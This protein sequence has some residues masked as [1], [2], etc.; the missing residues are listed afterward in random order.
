MTRR[1]R[2]HADRAS[3]ART[4][5]LGSTLAVGLALVST[6]AAAA[7]NDDVLVEFHF[8]PVPNTQIAI[9]LVDANGQFVQDVFVTQAT[10]TLGIGNR[11]GRWDFLSS[12]RF[13]YGPRPQVLPVWA[14]ARGKN[15]PSLKFHDDDPSD[16]DSLG[17]HENS[18]SPEP[19]FCRPLSEVENE[20]IS[21]DTMT[22]PSPA[23][24]QSD[25]GRF[26]G[27]QTPYPPRNDLVTFEDGGDHADVHMFGALNDLDA[28]TGATPVG[29]EP[30]LVTAIVPRAIAE[31]GPMTA[32]IEVNLEHDENDAWAFDRD[33]DHYV[34]P[35]LSGYGVEYLGQPSVVYQVQFE[36]L[37]AAFAGTDMYAGYG[38]WDGS[39]GD[40][41]EPDSSIS[42]DAG[43]GADRLSLYTK[44]GETF[45]FGVYSHGPG[46]GN[47]P[48]GGETTGDSSGESDSGDDGW[49]GGCDIHALPP[50][51]YFEL[52]AMD[53]DRVR[54]HFAIPADATTE[55]I[56]NVR[57]YYRSGTMALDE[58]N[59]GAAIQA[60][61]TLADCSGPFEP[62]VQMWC[63]VDELFGRYTYQI[64]LR[65]E[66][67]CSN[68]STLVA[69]MVETP[70]QK[71]QTVDGFCFIATAAWGGAWTDRV[72]ALRYFRDLYLR[73]TGFGTALVEFYYFNS[74][75]LAGLIAERPWARA[76]TRA[77]LSPV[78]DLA[79]AATRVQ[80][81][82]AG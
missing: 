62:G 70:A 19:Y 79:R 71:F 50:V 67:G 69:G 81:P 25:K 44:N 51:D 82:G 76:L 54:V 32:F 72:Q 37:Q 4:L 58:S 13:P 27:G 34:D 73:Q 6:P 66:D 52:E 46:S 3:L 28:V 2:R 8:Q 59:V 18:S 57:L 61:A 30:E 55:Q 9:W 49:G 74:P 16:A 20:T 78:A 47:D 65:Y 40:L 43:S 80:P 35:R 45:R 11:P 39:T 42:T 26:D 36:P 24:F 33:T 41:H 5:G 31:L 48:T 56:R 15:Y 38:E 77:V 14:H 75:K 1:A 63:D 23:T 68:R 53:F 29:D 17:W 22:C 60:T 7:D 64:G 10:G 21:T 12:W